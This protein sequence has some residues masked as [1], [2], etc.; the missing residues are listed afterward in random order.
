[1]TD[2]DELLKKFEAK[3]HKEYNIFCPYCNK[4]QSI[5]T[6]YECVTYHGDDGDKEI[7]CEDC[8]RKFIVKEIVDRTFESRKIGDDD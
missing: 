7:N 4:K 1:M 5:D 6:M 8:G 3:Y 2:T